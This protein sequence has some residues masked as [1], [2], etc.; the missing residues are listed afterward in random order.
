MVVDDHDRI[1][2]LALSV[3]R[4]VRKITGICLPH[5]AKGI[6]FKS[7]PVS[8]VGISGRLQIILLNEALYS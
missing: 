1:N 7:L 5:T 2:T 4:D 3:F 6:F 8:Q